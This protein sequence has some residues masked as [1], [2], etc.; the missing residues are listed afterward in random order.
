MLQKEHIQAICFDVDGTLNDTD[1]LAV[2][3]LARLLRPLRWAFA[4]GDARFAARRIV[5]WA[6]TPGNALISVPDRLG[7]DAGLMR[8]A[9]YFNR[10]AKPMHHFRLIAGVKEMLD[11]L[12][13][14]YLMSVVSARDEAS[15]RR[16]LET[17]GLS[18]YFVC[19]AG[20]LTVTHTKP[21]PDPI[22]WAAEQMHVPPEACLMVGDT[23]VDIRAGRAAGAQTVGVLCGFGERR[24]LE[25][26]GADLILETTPG[27]VDVLL[28]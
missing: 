1:D 18:E 4:G 21:Y 22:F 24:E 23:T 5:M 13:G 14:H 3:R 8:T 26:V 25:R 28:P 11:R 27:L 20:A 2:E 12:R 7:I 19:V 16:F 9:N 15:T 6:E 17:F 10:H